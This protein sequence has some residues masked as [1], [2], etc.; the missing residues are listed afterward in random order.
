MT[1]WPSCRFLDGRHVRPHYGRNYCTSPERASA[2]AEC[3]GPVCGQACMRRTA[4]G[5]RGSHAEGDL[6]EPVCGHPCSAGCSGT[7]GAKCTAERAHCVR[8]PCAGNRRVRERCGHRGAQSAARLAERARAS[9]LKHCRREP[10]EIPCA[11]TVAWIRRPGSSARRS[12]GSRMKQRESLPESL[13]GPQ[14]A[15]RQSDR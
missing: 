8:A 3:R 11:I 13:G 15:P 10:V 7:A 1:V 5:H 2:A 6:R 4:R 12:H 9:M 14:R